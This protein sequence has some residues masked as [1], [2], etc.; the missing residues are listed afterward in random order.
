MAGSNV[1]VQEAARY[2][3]LSRELRQ[4]SRTTKIDEDA[5][6]DLRDEF[7][8]LAQHTECPRIRALA[9]SG[10]VSVQGL[11]GPVSGVAS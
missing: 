10:L 4:F 8:A 5:L 6:E 7:A 1:R 3:E 9:Q 11:P 2:W